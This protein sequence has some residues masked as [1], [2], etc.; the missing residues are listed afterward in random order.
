[1]LTKQEM[2]TRAWNG[3]RAQGWK[4]SIN[5]SGSCRYKSPDG[6]RCAWGHVDPYGTDRPE[7]EGIGVR[8]LAREGI[9]I[10]AVLKGPEL[11]FAGKLQAAHDDSASGNNPSRSDMEAN[12]RALAAEHGLEVPE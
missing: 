2:F 4:L 12:L 8:R 7:A 3:L 5:P 10:A 1:M 11:S 9:G 6:Y